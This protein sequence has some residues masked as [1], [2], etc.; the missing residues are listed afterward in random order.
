MCTAISPVCA[1]ECVGAYGVSEDLLSVFVTTCGEISPSPVQKGDWL[2]TCRGT[3]MAENLRWT[4]G[5][6]VGI[7]CRYSQV[8]T[9]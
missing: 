8:K 2:L 6:D 5:S 7:V 3:C 1:T 9:A 4:L